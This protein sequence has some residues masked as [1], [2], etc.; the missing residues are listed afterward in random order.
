MTLPLFGDVGDR[1]GGRL[2]AAAQRHIDALRSLDLVRGQDELTVE[3]VLHLAFLLERAKPYSA[4]ALAQQLRD[5]IAAMPQPTGD[6]F[7]D[8]QAHLEALIDEAGAA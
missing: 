4:P 5:T 1:A 8:L 6:L 7:A 2:V 3:L